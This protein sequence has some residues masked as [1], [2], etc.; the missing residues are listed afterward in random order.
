MWQMD[1]LAKKEAD[2]KKMLQEKGMEF[3]SPDRD[4]FRK[5]SEGAYSSDFVKNLE[6]RASEIIKR[7]REIVAAN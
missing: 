2:Y 5:A 6:P 7:I 3:V 1:Y 4:A